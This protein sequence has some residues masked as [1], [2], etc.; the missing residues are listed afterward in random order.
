MTSWNTYCLI[1]MITFWNYITVL[2]NNIKNK[3]QDIFYYMKDYVYGYH[4][5]WLF[6]P[7][8]SLP[9]SLNNIYNPIDIDWIY[10]NYDNTFKLCSD[11]ND[12][13]VPYKFSWLSAKIQIVYSHTPDEAFEYNIDSF[14]EKFTVN[15]K[16]DIPPSLYLIFM[17]WCVYSKHWFTLDDNIEFHI[18]NDMGEEIIINLESHNSSIVIKRNKLYVVIN[19]KE[20]DSDKKVVQNTEDPIKDKQQKKN[21]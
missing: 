11:E 17:C 9:V 19:E 20:D 18:I 1:K 12:T 10:D 21:E 7:G 13:L 6:I 3:C 5:T 14:I 8:H 4:D 15:T 16:S 2:Y